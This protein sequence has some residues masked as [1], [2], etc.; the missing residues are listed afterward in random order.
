MLIIGIIINQYGTFSKE[1]VRRGIWLR[2]TEIFGLAAD[3]DQ[4]YA[5]LKSRKNLFI[6]EPIMVMYGIRDIVDAVREFNRAADHAGM[7]AAY[8][9]QLREYSSYE[10]AR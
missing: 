5:V 10:H 8:K 9:I 4:L 7:P 3:A 1:I 6:Y 2:C